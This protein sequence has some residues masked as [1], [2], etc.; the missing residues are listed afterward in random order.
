MASKAFG[1]RPFD[2]V[3]GVMLSCLLVTLACSDGYSCIYIGMH[4]FSE[5]EATGI[6]LTTSPV[7]DT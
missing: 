6:N 3:H 7:Q 1:A 2:H 4:D 5:S